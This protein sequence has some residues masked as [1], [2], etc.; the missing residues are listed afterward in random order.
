MMVTRRDAIV[1]FLD[2]HGGSVSAVGTA[3]S[4]LGTIA[5][6]VLTWTYVSYS[7]KQWQEMQTSN[8]TSRES[9]VSVQRAFVF[10]STLGI[11]PRFDQQSKEIPTWDIQFNWENSGATPARTV[12]SHLSWEFRDAPP[13]VNFDFPDRWVVGQP[14]DDSPTFIAPKARIGAPGLSVPRY[15]L[16][17]LQRGIGH[18]YYWGWVKYLDAFSQRHITEVCAELIPTSKNTDLSNGVPF[19]FDNCAN[20]KHNCADQD[21][22]DYKTKIN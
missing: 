5:I 19:R 9:L 18:F 2:R 10:D 12:L 21:C 3:V 14:H 6:V 11:L 4:A 1:A 22:E 20:H 8:Q 16:V 17:S 7:K 15:V 13:P